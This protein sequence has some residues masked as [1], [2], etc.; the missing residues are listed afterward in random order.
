VDTL[1][2]LSEELGTTDRTLR[3][4]VRLGLIHAERPSPRRIEITPDEKVYLRDHWALL[5]DLRRALRTEPSVETAILFGSAARGD[6]TDASDLDLAVALR[7]PSPIGRIEVR[8]RLEQALLKDV[9]L[10]DL[11][12][13]GRAP[14]LLLDVA[15]EGRPIVDRADNWARLQALKPR[16]QREARHHARETARQFAAITSKSE[17]A[18]A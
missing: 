10:I 7:D 16:L 6:M 8:D 3:R 4:A 5:R 2:R 13:A 18:V 14:E 17:A 12:S 15:T 1:N 11:P 9:H